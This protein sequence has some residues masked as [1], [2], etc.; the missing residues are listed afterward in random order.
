MQNLTDMRDAFF[1]QL[2]DY[3]SVDKNVMIL[4]ADHGAFGLKKIETDFP[5]QY[6]NVGIAE[7]SLISIAAGLAKCGKKVYVYA[8]NNFITLR[9]LEQINIDLC[10]MNLDVNIIGIGAGFT[11]STDGPT[12]HGIQDLSAMI[13]LPNIK[14]YNVTDDINTKKLAELSYMSSG[15]KY[16]RLEKGKLPR[17]YNDTDDINIGYKN[18]Q[19]SKN[20]FIIFSSG[21]MTQKTH[22]VVK[23]LQEENIFVGHTDIYNVKP[24]PTK[25][26]VKL[27]KDKHVIVIEENIKS[28]GLGEKI[29]CILK[30][31]G[32]TNKVLS[33]CLEDKF[34]FNYHV[35]RDQ[36]HLLAQIDEKS[37]HKKIKKLIDCVQPLNKK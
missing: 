35:D 9:V 19:L 2:Y 28:G 1:D 5:E 27:S 13:N 22:N 8:I 15:P 18:L 33:I 29:F 17:V 21:Y 26:I 12:H 34:Y 16:F 25:Q 23:K 7:Q 20:G 37:I 14:I 3:V 36:L 6:L 11:Y 4:T 24:L 30:E 31:S 10:A 32:H